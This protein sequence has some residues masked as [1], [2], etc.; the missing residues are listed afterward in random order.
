MGRVPAVRRVLIAVAAVFILAAACS[1]TDTSSTSTTNAAPVTT[2][3]A[4]ERPARTTTTAPPTSAAPVDVPA[5][6]V[7]CEPGSGPDFT[8]QELRSQDFAG[9]SLRCANFDGATLTGAN[10]ARADLSGSS[11]VGT[12][13]QQAAFQDAILIGTDF[14]A[15]IISQVRFNNADLTGALLADAEI[16]G[17]RFEGAT[18]PDGRPVQGGNCDAQLTPVPVTFEA[19]SVEVVLAPIEFVPLCEPDSGPDYTGDDLPEGGF[20][21]EDLRCADFTDATLAQPIF[22]NLDASG[23]VFAG[24]NFTQASFVG[25]KLFGASFDGASFDT[26]KFDN[27]NLIGAD[28]VNTT[29]ANTRWTNTICPNGVNSDQAGGT[30]LGS[31]TALDLPEVAFDEITAE[32]ITVRQGQGVTTYAI[33]ADVLFEFASAEIGTQAA[34]TIEEIIASISERFDDIVEIQVWGHADAIGD[35]RSNQELSQLRAD[36]VAALLMESLSDVAIVAIGLGE[37]QPIAPN[38]NPDGSDNPEGRAQNRRVEVVV[39]TG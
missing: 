2:A 38:T 25:T 3:A 9:E 28:I 12:T 17:G 23:A 6:V 13:L 24:A 22:D 31:R 10:L 18:C 21:G 20:R 26:A 4:R 35:R 36:N 15:A 27:A 39:R 37:A 14:S 16:T 32:G 33:E 29:F 11:F 19:S 34:E 7:D 8:G 30:C 5:V 1:S